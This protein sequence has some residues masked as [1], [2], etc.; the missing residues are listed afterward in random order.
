MNFIEKCKEAA[1]SL[2]NDVIVGAP[3]LGEVSDPLA[4]LRLPA[5]A[6]LGVMFTRSYAH[7]SPTAEPMLS[8]CLLP[9]IPV[10]VRI[11][12][13]K[14]HGVV[15]LTE[16]QARSIKEALLEQ[17]SSHGEVREIPPLLKSMM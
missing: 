10:E 15:Y 3:R 2:W 14:R 8:V 5:R 17:Y 7:L 11:R 1:G 6:D 9:D 12:D 13:P 16:E 4:G